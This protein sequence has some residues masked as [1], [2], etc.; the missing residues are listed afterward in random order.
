[1]YEPGMTNSRTVSVGILVSTVLLGACSLI[2]VNGKPLGGSS[3]GGSSGGSSDGSG[4]DGA[5]SG[6]PT[7]VGQRPAWCDEYNYSKS[8][9]YDPGYFDGMSDEDLESN[10]SLAQLFGE[11]VCANEWEKPE[12]RE[13][14]LALR[15]KWMK[16]MG[17][18]ERDFAVAAGE[19]KGYVVGERQKYDSLAGPVAQIADGYAS[20]GLVG[21]DQLGAKTSMVARFAVAEDCYQASMGLRHV[22][23]M[24]LL[25]LVLCSREQLDAGKAYAEI[26]KTTGLN[27]VTRRDLRRTV[28]VAGRA[29]AKA[30]ALVA[31]KAKEDPGIAKLVSIADQQFKEWA[32]PSATRAKLIANLEAM[33]AATKANKHSAFAGCEATTRA[34]WEDVLAS[35]DLP[36]VPSEHV[37]TTFVNATLG[38]AEGYLAY[39]ALRLCSA[40]QEDNFYKGGDII[41]SD[42][43]RRGPRTA[44]LAAWINASGEIKFDDRDLKMEDLLRGGSYNDGLG[45]VEGQRY[46]RIVRGVI[47]RID[48]KDGFVEISFKRVTEM[49]EDCVKWQQTNR[50]ESISAGGAIN[51]QYICK[52]W[53]KVKADLTANPI[54]TGKVTAQ[55]LKSGM[56]IMAI[57]DGLPVVATSGSSS[58]K[59]LWILGGAVR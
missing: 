30:T 5:A 12:D 41:G 42:V 50:I 23:E 27:D 29:A 18:D 59:P 3:G 24:P 20:N 57:E 2:K 6:G 8:T 11:V 19:G 39:K 44:T 15:A 55:G 32:S 26:D 56:Y 53:G 47:D 7:V 33:E 46:Q 31:A 51:Y 22:D 48:E 25:L 45:L 9:S 10:S 40:S 36:K 14:L 1:M 13:P 17:Y 21:L 37:L 34:A 43:T 54:K 28:T 4:G 49:V 38:T 16:L 35:L 52:A 58:S